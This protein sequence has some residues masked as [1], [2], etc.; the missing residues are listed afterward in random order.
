MKLPSLLQT[1]T[2]NMGFDFA[3]AKKQL[4]TTVMDTLG[5]D[6]FYSDDQTVV[7]VMIRARWHSK[8][9][10]FG[11]MGNAGYAEVIEGVERLI[12]NEEQARLLNVK[13]GGVVSFPS[14]GGGFVTLEAREPKDGPI[15]EIWS[16][17]ST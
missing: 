3:A 14:L 11:D 1:K 2:C 4:R 9:D 7:P 12:L 6:A 13:R 5:M 10:R 16:V 17:T 8:I 15:E